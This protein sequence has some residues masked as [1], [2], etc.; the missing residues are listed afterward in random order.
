[1]YSNPQVIR[2]SSKIT[3]ASGNSVKENLLTRDNN[4]LHRIEPSTVPRTMSEA[5]LSA[6]FDL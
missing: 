5:Y 3:A 6:M 1:M 2:V 4:C